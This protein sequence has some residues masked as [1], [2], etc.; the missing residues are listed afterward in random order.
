MTSRDETGYNT[1]GIGFI[2]SLD[3]SFP[4]WR[5]DVKSAV[6]LGAGGAAYSVTEALKAAGKKVYVLNRTIMNA[7]KLCSTLGAEMYLNQPAEMIVN[8]TSLGL[9]GEDV[10]YSMC[11]LPEFEYGFDLIYSPER[12]P[13]TDRLERGGARVE[14]GMD[15][16]AYQAIEGDR[17]LFGDR[18]EPFDTQTVFLEVDKI[19]KKERGK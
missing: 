18:V 1:D 3:A 10:L 12:T 4:D 11:L 16:L 17:I 5:A 15:M 9:N 14:N 8:C 13:F 19:L 7:A 6:V 2:C